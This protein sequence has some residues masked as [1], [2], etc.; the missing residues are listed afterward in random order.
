MPSQRFSPNIIGLVLAGGNSSRMGKDKSRMNY[1]GIPQA[2]WMKGLLMPYCESVYISVRQFKNGLALPQLRDHSRWDDIG[3]MNAVL[4][5]FGQFPE[6]AFFIAGCDYLYCEKETIQLLLDNRK[7]EMDAVAFINP[8]TNRPEPLLTVYEP[9][10]FTKII[11]QYEAGNHS[12]QRVLEH[13]NTEL[14]N[15]PEDRWI[16]SVDTPEDV[17]NFQQSLVV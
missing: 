13:L 6:H 17:V 2:N 11:A 5:A 8:S 16:K 12:L 1:H 10:A 15:L 3:P 4:T 14:V 9:S 7:P